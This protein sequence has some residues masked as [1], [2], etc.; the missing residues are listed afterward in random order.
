MTYIIQR[1]DRFYV[2]AYDGLDPLTGKERRR[3]HPA[4]RDRAEAETMAIRLD[5]ERDLPPPRAGG[6]ITVGEFLTDTWLPRK[7]R[8][9]RATT[10][11]RYAW[12]IDRYIL[13]AIGDVPLRRLRLDHLEAFY[14]QLATTGGR[15]H[16]G[17]APKTVREV[18]MIIRAAL[19]LAVQREV[20]GRNVAAAAHLRPARAGNAVAR[21]WTGAE[22]ARFLDAARLHRLYP[23]LH[24]AAHTGMRRGEIVG[25]KWCDLDITQRRLAIR[26]TMQCVGG[27][28]VEFGVKTRTSRRSVELDCGTVTRLS[29]W[30]RRVQ[31]DGLPA[32]I[33]DWMFCN[34]AGRYLNPQ[35][36]SQLFDRIVTAAELPRVRFH[37]LRHTHASL[38]IASGEDVKVVSERLGHANVAF[39]MHT[40]Q[41]LLPGMSAAAARQFAA[42]LAAHSR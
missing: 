15:H 7:R 9:V 8:Q 38:L 6:P 33:D 5:S 12:F 18:H 30:R 37:D 4:G 14:G 31:R 1:Q 29:R 17:L 10:A 25:L 2:V 13:P 35:S 23:A 32:G 20:V 19:D 36:M 41:H 21:T 34:T 22:L 16:S 42:L 40:Y 28:P 3:W 27:Q 39:T 11:Y 24:L 26:R